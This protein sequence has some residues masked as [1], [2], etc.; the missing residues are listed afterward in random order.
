MSSSLTD[1]EGHRHFIA[2]KMY[3]AETEAIGWESDDQNQQKVVHVVIIKHTLKV[4]GT[5]LATSRGWVRSFPSVSSSMQILSFFLKENTLFPKMHQIC[6]QV[7]INT[8]QP[9]KYVTLYGCFDKPTIRKKFVIIVFKS[10]IL[11]TPKE[12]IPFLY[13]IF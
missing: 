1:F 9:L 12:A 11:K 4:Y 7:T 3:E 6:L 13:I 2:Q 8:F 5:S 10:T